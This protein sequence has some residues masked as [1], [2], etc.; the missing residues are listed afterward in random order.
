MQGCRF[1]HNLAIAPNATSSLV[2]GTTSPS[3]EPFSSNAFTQKTHS[4]VFLI[5]NKHLEKLL[6]DTYGFTPEKIESTFRDITLNKGSV[7]HLD[8]L[9]ELER[10]TFKT[11]IELDQ[12]WIIQHAADRQPFIDQGQSVNLFV[13]PTITKGELHK[14]HHMAWKMGLKSLYY[15]RSKSV[16]STET[17]SNEPKGE[18]IIDFKNKNTTECK[19]CEG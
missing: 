17:I 2:C 18:T 4:G 9:S 14:L 11:A 15:C 8:F 7:Q 3:I 10:D 19:S 1:S 12:E 13:Q 6:R 16:G 5:K